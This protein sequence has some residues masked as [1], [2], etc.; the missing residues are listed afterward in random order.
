LA[1]V[2]VSIGSNI[3]RYR[4]IGACLDAL[5][6]QFG[7]LVLSPVYESESVGFSGDPFLN[8]VARFH[9]SLPV[10]A[11]SV[12][13]R[14]IEYDNGRRRQ[15]PKFSARAMDI[16]ILTYDQCVGIIDGVELPRGEITENAFVLQPLTDIAAD[17]QHPQLRRSYAALW[18]DYDQSSQALWPVDFRWRGAL[19]PMCSE[20]T[21]QVWL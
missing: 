10:G 11:L 14:Q 1:L 16:D 6:L 13:L 2:Y 3:D 17:E 7:A 5:A 12:A 4:R 9:C 18:R 15:G 8:L 19:L 20:P 21:P